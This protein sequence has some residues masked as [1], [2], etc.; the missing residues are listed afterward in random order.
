[1]DMST[2]EICTNVIN[3]N[4]N[5]DKKERRILIQKFVIVRLG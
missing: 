5:N 1:M 4:N 3:N 2:R